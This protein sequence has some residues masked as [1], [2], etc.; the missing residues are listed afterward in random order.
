[1]ARKRR[2]RKKRVRVRAHKRRTKKGKKV[3]VRSHY[4]KLPR[5]IKIV[6]RQTGTRKSINADRKRIA[7]EPGK[8]ISKS[9]RIYWETRKNRSDKPGSKI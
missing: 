8:R 1:M 2:R 7:L 4:R 9:G 6:K 5:T 3:K